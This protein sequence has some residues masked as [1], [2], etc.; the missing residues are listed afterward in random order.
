MTEPIIGLLGKLRHA[1]LLE[2]LGRDAL[3]GNFLGDGFRAVFAIFRVRAM[4]VRIGP[5]T[6]GTIDA[7]KLIEA[8]EGGPAANDSRL[9]QG[10][11]ER[12]L[13]CRGTARHLVAFAHSD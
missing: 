10:K 13:D 1:P 7:I 4:A 3:R 8:I 11:F 6:A 9:A 12:F 2:K 5:R